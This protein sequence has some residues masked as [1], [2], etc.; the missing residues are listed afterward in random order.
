MGLKDKFLFSETSGSI[1][2]S[3]FQVYNRLGIGFEKQHYIK[4]LTHELKVLGISYEFNKY[5]GLYYDK[6][7]IGDFLVDII[8]NDQIIIMIET[9][10]FIDPIKG[11]ILQ[12][13]LKSSIYE[14]GLLLN[15]GNTPEYLR[16]QFTNDIKDSVD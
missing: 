9:D 10:S 1:L 3:Y 13:K 5:I 4:A 15:F 2:K 6:L 11:Q 12:N 8:V 14:V 7:D 16:K